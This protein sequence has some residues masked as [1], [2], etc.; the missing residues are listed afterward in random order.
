MNCCAISF[1]CLQCLWPQREPQDSLQVCAHGLSLADSRSKHQ[2]WLM[3]KAD[4]F[5]QLLRLAPPVGLSSVSAH[6]KSLWCVSLCFIFF[7]D[8][9]GPFC[10]DCT[11]KCFGMSHL[12]LLR[13]LLILLYKCETP[14]LLPEDLSFSLTLLLLYFALNL[15]QFLPSALY[16]LPATALF[17]PVMHIHSNPSHHPEISLFLCLFGFFNYFDLWDC[18]IYRRGWELEQAAILL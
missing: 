7:E 10:F 1:I 9:F 2:S 18:T 6:W 11:D 17:L 14:Y 16:S 12:A 15:L 13:I 3:L 8:Q 5:T 4:L